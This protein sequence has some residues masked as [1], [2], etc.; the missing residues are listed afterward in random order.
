MVSEIRGSTQG[1]LSKLVLKETAVTGALS[2]SSPST[3]GIEQITQKA[4]QTNVVSAPEVQQVVQEPQ[5]GKHLDVL[6]SYLPLIY[7]AYSA[8]WS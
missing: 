6:A 5:L 8:Y 3:E 7:S 1:G 4:K 2:K